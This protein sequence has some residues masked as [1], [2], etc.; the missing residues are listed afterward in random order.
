MKYVGVAVLLA[1]SERLV[2]WRPGVDAVGG[3]LP[4][5]QSLHNRCAAGM[6]L[7]GIECMLTPSYR[8]EEIV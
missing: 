3:I 8:Y 2:G 6:L 5:K 1:L 4:Q 7:A